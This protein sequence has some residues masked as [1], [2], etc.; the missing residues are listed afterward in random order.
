ME[1]FDSRVQEMLIQA[2]WNEQDFCRELIGEEGQSIQVLYPGKWNYHEGPDFLDAVVKIN[3]IK[4][5]GDIEIHFRPSDW[6]SHGHAGDPRYKNVLLHVVWELNKLADS[7]I[8]PPLLELKKHCAL[9]LP[10]IQRKYQLQTYGRQQQIKPTTSALQ[11]SKLSDDDLMNILDKSGA[12]RL[13]Q[14]ANKFEADCLQVGLEQAL[15]QNIMEVMGY[16]KNRTAFLSLAKSASTKKLQTYE[17]HEKIAIIWGESGLLPDPSQNSIHPDQQEALTTLWDAWWPHRQ[18][19]NGSIKWSRNGRPVN[20]PERRLAGFICFMQEIQWGLG[21]FFNKLTQQASIHIYLETFFQTQTHWSKFMNFEKELKQAMALIGQSRVQELKANVL[22]PA[23]V[24]HSRKNKN[25]NIEQLINDYRS[26]K[27][28]EVTSLL[29]EASCRFFIPPARMKAVVKTFMHQQGLLQL[30]KQ[31][32]DFDRFA[33]S[34]K[35]IV[36]VVSE[37][38]E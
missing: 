17:N 21:S 33:K 36:E 1:V 23:L 24:A 13:A 4:Q 11:I 25:H 27:K 26:M 30:L 32:H 12:H 7:P 5:L 16:S 15:Y 8:D 2:L 37:D 14:K 38:A 9:S 20:S 18:A 3:G 22:I 34:S 35:P 6:N 29:K 19:Y 31:P 10:Q 28:G